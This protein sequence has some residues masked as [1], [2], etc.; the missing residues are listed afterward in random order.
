MYCLPRS[1]DRQAYELL[2]TGE[3]IDAPKRIGSASSAGWSP[4]E[5]AGG[6]KPSPANRDNRPC[7]CG[8]QE[9]VRVASDTMSWPWAS[10]VTI[11]LNL[12]EDEDHKEGA[13]ASWK[14][15]TLFRG[16]RK[17]GA[18]VSTRGL[19]FVKFAN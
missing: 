1:S 14:A 3:V 11:P 19:L 13:N 6:A 5:A 10:S 16:D 8:D 15:Q 7:G 2:Y 4:R 12:F 9:G 17:K 18:S